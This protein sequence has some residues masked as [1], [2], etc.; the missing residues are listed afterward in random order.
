MN[1]RNPAL[2]SLAAKCPVCMLCGAANVGQVVACHSNSQSD[3]KGMGIKASDA[4]VAFCCDTCHREIDQGGQSKAWKREAWLDAYRATMRWLIET[5]H[6]LVS[7]VPTPPPVVATK[8]SRKIAKSKRPIAAR[9]DPW[10]KGRSLPS[11]PMARNASTTARR[12]EPR[13]DQKDGAP[14]PTTTWS[15]DGRVG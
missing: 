15:Q 6:L 7:M 3:G 12:Q 14:P 11:R 1:Y 2:L 8:P 5:G 9:V 13:D 4:C 10:P